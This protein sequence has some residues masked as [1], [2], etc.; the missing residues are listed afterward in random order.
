MA[1][2]DI[3]CS[4]IPA[5][6]AAWR[7][8]AAAAAAAAHNQQEDCKKY[9]EKKR[10]EAEQPVQVPAVDSSEPKTLERR[11]ITIR[12]DPL[13]LLRPQQ[14]QA[15]KQFNRC[16]R[17]VVVISDDYLDSEECDF[18]TKFALSLSP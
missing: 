1:A 3:G 11:G 12:D 2:A 13:G 6:K 9:L 10:Q 18:Q 16:R 7:D 15:G 17:M 8:A 4:N 14:L 5:V